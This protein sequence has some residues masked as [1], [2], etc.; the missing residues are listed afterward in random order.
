[1]AGPAAAVTRVMPS[2]AFAV[3][4]DAADEAL[5]AAS[6][7]A[8]VAFCVVVDSNRTIWRPTEKADRLVAIAKDMAGM[9]RVCVDVGRKSGKRR[10]WLAARGR[11]WGASRRRAGE[12]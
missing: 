6:L 3:Y 11:R 12:D 10:N 8:P 7:A 2:E 9:R 1:M 4:S 5:E